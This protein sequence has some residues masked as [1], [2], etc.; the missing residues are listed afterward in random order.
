MDQIVRFLLLK[1]HSLAERCFSCQDDPTID[2][3]HMLGERGIAFRSLAAGFDTTTT[4][5]EFL[6]HIM[7]TLAQMERRMIVGRTHA[8]A[9]TDTR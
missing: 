3:V 1:D 7:A 5:G 2:T 8:D 9:V 6:F 4:D